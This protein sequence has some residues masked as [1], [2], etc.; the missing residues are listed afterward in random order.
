MHE[1]ACV[2]L[3]VCVC[4]EVCVCGCVYVC[5]CV[6]TQRGNDYKSNEFT[7]SKVVSMK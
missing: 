6:Y 4:M 5:V 3:C 1:S 2:W 7:A